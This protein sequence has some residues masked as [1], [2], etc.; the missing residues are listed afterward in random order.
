MASAAWDNKAEDSYQRTAYVHSL[1]AI[2][3][4]EPSVQFG[5][6]VDL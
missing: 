1:S 3:E 4:S 5:A 6:Y 2:R